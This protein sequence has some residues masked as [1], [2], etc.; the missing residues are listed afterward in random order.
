MRIYHPSEAM[1]RAA[2]HTMHVAPAAEPE[3]A[4]GPVEWRDEDGLPV[5]IPV[6]F[7]FGRAEVPSPLGKFMVAKGYANRTALIMPAGFRALAA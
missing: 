4:D 6:T 2:R 5:T 3:G 7:E 1:R